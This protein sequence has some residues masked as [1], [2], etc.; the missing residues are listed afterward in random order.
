M[1]RVGLLI[2][3]CVLI[4]FWFITSSEGYPSRSGR[5][6]VVPTKVDLVWKFKNVF[7]LNPTEKNQVT[8][9]CAD[10][11]TYYIPIINRNRL[12]V[13]SVHADD[14]VS[15]DKVKS[16]P[17]LCSRAT[18]TPYKSCPYAS[19][20]RRSLSLIFYH[21]VEYNTSVRIIDREGIDAPYLYICKKISSLYPWQSFRTCFGSLGSFLSSFSIL[22]SS[23]RSFLCG[24][25]SGLSRAPQEPIENSEGGSNASDPNSSNAA[26]E[27]VK[28]LFVCLICF[29]LG[30]ILSYRAGNSLYDERPLVRALLVG[31]GILIGVGG[32]LFSVLS[33]FWVSI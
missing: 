11:R 1:K 6:I 26:Y 10:C 27:I 31:T 15:F 14:M 18:T 12:R 28:R 13:C 3:L 29:V 22:E 4:G 25:G 32:V 24:Y 30:S 21:E 19:D 9:R 23:I 8:F 7:V 20:Y 2:G 16:S 17:I 5:G 33:V